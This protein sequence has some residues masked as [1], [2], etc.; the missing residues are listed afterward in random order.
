MCEAEGSLLCVQS[1]SIIV[2]LYLVTVTC[3]LLL[4]E[5]AEEGKTLRTDDVVS[6]HGEKVQMWIQMNQHDAHSSVSMRG[7]SLGV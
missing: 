1:K 7:S 3:R 6:S 2:Q 5:T 4:D